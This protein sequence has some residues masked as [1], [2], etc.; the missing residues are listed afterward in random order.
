M[1]SSNITNEVF[2]FL[3]D[4]VIIVVVVL[5][6]KTFLVSPFQIKWD[7][8]FD[9]YYDWEFIIVDRFSYLTI[10]NIKKWLPNRWDVVVFRPWVNEDKEY[11]IKRVIGTPWDTLKIEDWK[12]YLKIE[13]QSDF[14]E[15]DEQYLSER[16]SGAT[17]VA[18]DTAERIYVVPAW[19]YFVSWDNRG[20][21]TDSRTCFYSCSA[22]K[23][24]FIKKEAIVWKLL[25]DLGYFNF[26]EFAFE[27]PKLGISTFPRF[28][29]SPDSYDY[30]NG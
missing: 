30:N 9:S 18:W 19:E 1:E 25:I 7:S 6:V 10:P 17:Y 14:A 2:D 15:L 21:S 3:K 27:H 22:W 12:V 24:P 4:I 28:F 20:A 16:N 26:K 8:M 23:T 5:I 13:W 11:F 29:S